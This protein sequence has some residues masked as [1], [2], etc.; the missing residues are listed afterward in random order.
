MERSAAEA[1]PSPAY[2]YSTKRFLTLLAA[3][4]C[5]LGA[6]P[7]TAAAQFRADSAGRDAKR[8]IGDMWSIWSSPAH[9]NARGAEGVALVAGQTAASAFADEPL[10]RWMVNHPDSWPMRVLLHPLTEEARYP[11][12]ELGSGQYLLPLSGVLYVAGTMSRSRP[13]RDAGLGCATAH[14]TSAG[15][16]DIVYL[17]IQRDRPRDAPD[18]PFRIRFPGTRNWN[19]HSF[20]S[21]HIANSMGCAS[22]FAHR[23][24]LHAAEPLLY[25]FVSAIGIGRIAD[26]RHWLSDTVAGAAFGYVVGRTVSARMLK[27]ERSPEVGGASPATVSISFPF[28]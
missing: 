11:A 2:G 28:D 5:G 19:A 4:V 7:S 10:H 13:L 8:A 12:Y 18:D 9:V 27:R 3:A 21:G 25:A 23:F 22:F 14:L 15:A 26:G 6:Q 1:D 17:L 16:R 20:F 24:A